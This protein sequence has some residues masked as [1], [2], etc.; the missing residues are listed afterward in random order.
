MV[1]FRCPKDC[2]GRRLPA[3]HDHCTEY[4]KAKAQNESEKAV[5][6]EREKIEQYFK[7]QYRNRRSIE[8]KEYQKR[9]AHH[10]RPKS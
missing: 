4:K 1:N 10:R 6:K 3:C 2:P 5:K 9:Y 8:A 7:A